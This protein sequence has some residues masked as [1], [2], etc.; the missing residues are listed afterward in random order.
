MGFDLA[1]KQVKKI[2]KQ[3]EKQYRYVYLIGYS[4]GATIVWL[5]SGEDI[6]CDVS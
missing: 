4:I 5:F 1:F 3:A 6:M 2:I